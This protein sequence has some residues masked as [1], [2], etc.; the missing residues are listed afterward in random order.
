MS[1]LPSCAQR[2]RR[3]GVPLWKYYYESRNMLYVHLRVK[4]RLGRYP[5]NMSLLLARAI[6]REKDGHLRR[7]AVIVRGLS[8]GARGKLGVRYPVEPMRERTPSL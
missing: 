3:E 2:Y 8:D 4:R 7:L 6:F 1:S 5:R